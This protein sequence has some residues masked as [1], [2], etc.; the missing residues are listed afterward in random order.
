M[1]RLLLLAIGLIFTV[2]AIAPFSTYDHTAAAAS[3]V[4]F[5]DTKGHWAEKTIKEMVERGILD[6]Y[7]DGTFR[8]QDPVKVD[9]FVKMLILSYSD[10]HQNGSRSW[11]ADFLNALSPDNQ[12]ILKQDYRYFSFKPNTTGYWAKDFIDIASDLHFLNKSRYSDFQ[13][14]MT[15]ENVAEI[16]Y[17]TLQEIEYLEDGV[18]GQKMAQSYGDI[19]GAS[20]REQ[21]FIAEALVKGIM[22]G[23]PNG[24][25]GVGEKVTRAQALV[26]LNRLTDKSQRIK[27]KLSPDKLERAVPTAG[28]GTKIVVF[29]DQRMWDAY[30]AL[31][32]IGQLR[33][34]NHD[35]LGTTLRMYKDQEQMKSVQNQSA[36]AT[37][38]YE[39]AAIWLDPDYNTYGVTIRLKDGAF[40]RNQE[41]VGQFSNSL[42]GYNSIAFKELFNDI[43]TKVEKGEAVTTTH[44]QIGTDT[45]TIMVDA[46]NKTVVFSIANKK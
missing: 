18:F 19:K 38:V 46:A 22:E 43:C 10:L 14:D 9:Q 24:F 28:G 35:L 36:G 31:I 13:A 20:E 5:T 17:Y 21:R 1:K 4:T 37:A 25:F 44:A 30:E 3:S 8:P 7:P 27:I 15:R 12:A 41:A 40:A 6:G 23:Y 26:I 11:N 42:F 39:E 45:I 2:S 34:A 32:G 33:G 29:P 16:V